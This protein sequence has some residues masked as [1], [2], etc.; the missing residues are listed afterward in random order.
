MQI[1]YLIVIC[2]FTPILFTHAKQLRGMLNRH[3]LLLLL[4]LVLWSVLVVNKNNKK[5]IGNKNAFSHTR[6]SIV[7]FFSSRKTNAISRERQMLDGSG[8][9]KTGGS[10]ISPHHHRPSLLATILYLVLGV[11]RRQR[12]V[13]ASFTLPTKQPITL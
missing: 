9:R 3:L 11:N 13:R 6:V 10:T 7:C 5:N 2:F 1:K 8:P 12:G 4:L